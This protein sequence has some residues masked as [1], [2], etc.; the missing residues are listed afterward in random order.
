VF[1]LDSAHS[2]APA[3]VSR[4]APV[5][6]AVRKPARKAPAKAI[7]APPARPVRATAKADAADE[8]EEF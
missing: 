5:P 1:K 7:A 3:A 8:W 2:V 6:A 4:P